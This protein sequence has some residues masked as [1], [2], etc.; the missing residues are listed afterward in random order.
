MIQRSSLASRICGTAALVLLTCCAARL[1]AAAPGAAVSG[2]S[3]SAAACTPAEERGRTTEVQARRPAM[4]VRT[5]GE[6]GRTTKVQTRTAE[7]QT[8]TAEVQTR[9]AEAPLRTAPSDDRSKRARHL[10]P[11]GRSQHTFFANAGYTAILSTIYL[12]KSSSGSLNEGLEITAGYNWTSRRGLGVGVVYSGGFISARRG[13]FER[14]SRIHYIAPE[15]VA[16]QRVGR[17]WLF[18]ENAG[19]GYGRYIRSYA[20]LTGSRGGV[21][22]HESVSAEFMLT[23]FL[24][25]GVTVGGQWLIVDS[26]DV[27]DGAELNLAGIFRVQLGGGIRF[28]F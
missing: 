8:R 13:G 18:R 12:R 14:T 6:R 20:G 26:P 23:R 17:R 1:H 10:A 16:R 7:V 11:R 28:Y 22:I 21:G 27:D 24:G 5:T 15:F 4:Q 25:L 3:G 19:I 9:T 2:T